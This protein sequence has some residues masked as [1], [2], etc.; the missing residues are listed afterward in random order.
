MIIIFGVG[1][2]LFSFR[3]EKKLFPIAEKNL[4]FYLE[5]LNQ[6]MKT[7]PQEKAFESLAQ[8]YGILVRQEG[9]EKFADIY[10]LPSFRRIDKEDEHFSDKLQVGKE[11]RFLFASIRDQNPRTVWFINVRHFPKGFGFSFVWVILFFVIILAL[12]FLTIRWII[13]PLKILTTGVEEITKGNLKFRFD[14]RSQNEISTIA[15]A[16]NKMAANI[17]TMIQ[18]KE[19]LLRDVSHELRSPL[20][21]IKVAS[22]LVAD[23]RIQNSITNDVNKM[24]VMIA[25]ILETAKIKSSIKSLHLVDVDFSELFRNLQN[26][27]QMEDVDLIFLKTQDSHQVPILK[28]IDLLQIERLLRNLI[29]N[30]IK[31]KRGSLAKIEVSFDQKDTTQILKIKDYGI[32]IPSHSLPHIFEPFY[33]ID[34]ARSHDGFGLGLSICK[35]IVEAHQGSISVHSQMNHYTE[36]EIHLPS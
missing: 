23:S 17:E 36:F 35:A 3:P 11:G 6:K 9:Q 2:I 31:Y 8:D 26:D 13:S 22:D 10:G 28:R 21:R 20:T 34:Q 14:I 33:R 27:Y 18:D 4:I 12:S 30:A 25:G 19:R 29:E 7:Y 24:E 1:V 16:F 5:S 15:D 32:G